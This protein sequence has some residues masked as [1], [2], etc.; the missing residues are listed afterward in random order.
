MNTILMRANTME[1]IRP[2]SNDERRADW[3]SKFFAMGFHR[4]PSKPRVKVT[5]QASIHVQRQA[6]SGASNTGTNG[7]DDSWLR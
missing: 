3:A 5:V 4:T 7:L 2:R 6:G 1:S